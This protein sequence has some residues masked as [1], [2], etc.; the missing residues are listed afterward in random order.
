MDGC[1][2]R[3]VCM[4]SFDAGEANAH[5]IRVIDALLRP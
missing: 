1:V 5:F 4:Q 2:G 3:G